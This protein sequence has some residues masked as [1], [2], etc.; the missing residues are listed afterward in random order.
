MLCASNS[1]ITL[2]S[3][4]G[5]VLQRDPQPREPAR[6]GEVAQQHVGEQP[7]VDVAAG[8]HEA[9]LLAGEPL[10]VRHHRGQPGRAGALDHG[11]LD[12]QQQRDRGL[13]VGLADQ[14]DVVDHPL[15]HARG[16]RARLLDRDALGQRVAAARQRLAPDLAV[17]RR[18]SCG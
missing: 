1:C 11:L 10:A 6:A 3:A 5:T 14:H 15:D 12:L 16:E 4:P 13:E 8:Q 7:R 18:N 2:S 17:H 9:D